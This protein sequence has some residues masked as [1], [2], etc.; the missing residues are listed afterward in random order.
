MAMAAGVLVPTAAHADTTYRY[1][2]YWTGG[3]QWA[4]STRGPGFRV[5]PSDGVEGW[6]FVV[7]PRDGSQATPPGVASQ[8][9]QLCPGQ[10]PAQPGRKRVAVVIDFGPA[11]IAPAGET[12]PDRSVTCVTADQ[13]ATGLQV[14]QQVGQLRFHSSGLICAVA[15]Y[16]ATECPGQSATS[17]APTAS[18]SVKSPAAT[19]AP[20]AP[21][22]SVAPE[23]PTR[24]TGSA[25]PSPA[26]TVSASPLATD[27]PSPVALPVDSSPPP[28]G[29]SS[30]P[31]WIAAIGAALIALLLGMAL[32]A[33]R[34]RE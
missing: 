6:R 19:V 1:W 8:Y 20:G 23:P 27:Q 22:T 17:A 31:A 14:I 34:G 33:R 25:N 26:P 28:A 9:A 7:S 21:K 12:P 24:A 18:P 13:N 11:G 3:D 29:P 15:G 2:S 16:P 4:Y 32:L 30:P 10:P 5:P